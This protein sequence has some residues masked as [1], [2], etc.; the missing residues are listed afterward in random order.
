MARALEFTFHGQS[1]KGSLQKVE[2]SDLYGSID[3]ETRDRAGLRCSVA[4]LASDG[5]TLIQTGGTAIGQFDTVGRWL[6][7]ADLVAVDKRGTRI[8]TVAS[9]F[10]APIAIEAKMT[11]ER[12]LD[13]SIRLAYAIDAIDPV[14]PA[15]AGDLDGGAIFRFDFSY[16]G[17]TNPDPAFMLKG[18]DG[19]L[20]MLVGSENNLNYVGFAQTAGLAEPDA[21]D[22]TDGDEI[23]FGM[24]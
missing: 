10:D 4:T 6:E 13:H 18:A 8:N 19:T 7:R 21:A 1:F 23:D 20:W 3:V 9:S 2:R 17:G 5:R 22:E 16:R 14:P 15:L 12:F 11:P 24:M